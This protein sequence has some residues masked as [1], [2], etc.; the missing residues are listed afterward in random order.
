[1]GGTRIGY[2]WGFHSFIAAL[3]AQTNFQ[4]V[5]IMFMLNLL[6]LYTIF[7]IAYSFAK[8][9]GLK[10]GY[11]YILPFAM[12]G[13]MRLDAGILFLLKLLS[14]KLISLKEIIAFP[15]EPSEVITNWLHGLPWYDSR[16]LFL[17][18][19]YNVSGMLLGM[20]LCF[21]YLLLLLLTLKEEFIKNKIY[22]I[23]LVFVISASFLNYPPLAIFP[24]IHAPIWI[25]FV[26]L[27]QSGDFKKRIGM[28]IKIIMPYV[29]SIL[30]ILPYLFYVL[31]SREV[32]SG[33][34]KPISLIFY[35]QSVKNII[36]FLLP[37]PIII[38]GV[39]VAF[40][41][42]SFSRE[43]FF[44][45]IGT[46]LSI[47]LSLFTRLPYDDSYKFNYILTLFFALFFLLGLSGWLSG[48]TRRWAKILIII[49]ICVFLLLTPFLLE[50]SHIVSSL[51]T[52]YIYTFFGRHILFAQD[53]QKNEAYTWIREN[54]PAKALV[55]LSYTE[56]KWS[57]GGFDGNYEPAALAER[58]LYVIRDDDFI[59]PNPEYKRRIQFRKE[60]FLNPVDPKAIDYFS[61]LNRPVYLLVEEKLPEN[62][63]VEPVFKQFPDNPGKPFSL[64][65]S[66]GR[67]R[68]YLV[69]PDKL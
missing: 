58:S 60:L 28:T 62:R 59:A 53:K 55:M 2:Y 5:Q 16:L 43:L 33:Q 30:I 13:L 11:R 67:Q 15:V 12:I 49:N 41:R 19:L 56:T 54:T 63:F 25:C 51:S 50:A 35:N 18:K 66:N 34:G 22:L 29:V 68:V 23:S 27:S 48:F 52:D 38:Y 44:L 21:A 61:S 6:S 1:M 26:F 9:F 69:H 10:E 36:A 7:C 3:T 64:V 32:S 31:S 57:F 40:K 42:L 4:Q 65:F 8:F 47:C 17:S 37:S 20:C 39:W 14:G 24:L 46:L 45:L